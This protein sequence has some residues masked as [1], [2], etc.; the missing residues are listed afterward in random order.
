M[1]RL[2]SVDLPALGGPIMETTSSALAFVLI[3]CLGICVDVILWLE[4]SELRRPAVSTKRHNRLIKFAILKYN[5]GM[6]IQLKILLNNE[7]GGGGSSWFCVW[8]GRCC[9]ALVLSVLPD[10]LVCPSPQK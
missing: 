1:S 10:G 5:I 3:L 9:V 7:E 6:Q 4:T 2:N 8:G